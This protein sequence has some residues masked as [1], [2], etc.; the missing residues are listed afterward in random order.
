M[1]SQIDERRQTHRLGTAAIF[2]KRLG[3]HWSLTAN[4]SSELFT[5]H[6]ALTQHLSNIHSRKAVCIGTRPT[7]NSG[8]P[9]RFT[10][11]S[12]VNNHLR[13]SVDFPCVNPCPCIRSQ[14]QE[15]LAVLVDDKFCCRV[16]VHVFVNCWSYHS[17]NYRL[18]FVYEH[19]HYH[20]NIISW[21]NTK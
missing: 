13:V 5:L 16:L 17:L 10:N 3:D 1:L 9:E 18:R 7:I 8:L 21:Y 19:Q 12:A 15:T 4:E 6:S 20:L 11:W 2:N 14:L